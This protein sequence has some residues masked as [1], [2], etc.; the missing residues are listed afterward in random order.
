MSDHQAAVTAT[1]TAVQQEQ[2]KQQQQQK[3]R[4]NG[5]NGVVHSTILRAS[6][7]RPQS[8]AAAMRADQKSSGGGLL[9]K[10]LEIEK[11]ESMRRVN[12]GRDVRKRNNRF[13]GIYQ[14]KECPVSA[15]RESD[16]D[17]DERYDDGPV[18][19]NRSAA[20]TDEHGNPSATA[21][22]GTSSDATT[23]ATTATKPVIKSGPIALNKRIIYSHNN[24]VEAMKFPTACAKRSKKNLVFAKVS[25]LGHIYSVIWYMCSAMFMKVNNC[26]VALSSHYCGYKYLPPYLYLYLL[27]FLLLW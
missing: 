18:E 13:A 27:L 1:E 23:A 8:G 6:Q 14:L 9:T 15:D 3:N 26:F 5:S 21:A 2:Q 16:E 24:S 20:G 7:Y 19:N 22:G 4:S 11:K 25:K 10:L 17:D 12:G